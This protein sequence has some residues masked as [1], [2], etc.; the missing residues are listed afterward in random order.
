MKCY[1]QKTKL[2]GQRENLPGRLRGPG[3]FSL[4]VEAHGH[5]VRGRAF[6]PCGVDGGDVKN[7]RSGGAARR[8]PD[9]EFGRQWRVVF[10]VE[11]E[12][13]AVNRRIEAVARVGR[14]AGP[15]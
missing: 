8:V 14:A 7:E 11:V 15:A 12:G 4:L 9:D 2:R 3:V 1:G 6:P 5:L 13:D 10:F